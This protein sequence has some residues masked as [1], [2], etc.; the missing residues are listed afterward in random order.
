MPRVALVDATGANKGLIL[1]NTLGLTLAT[2]LDDAEALKHA[3]LLVFNTNETD[4]SAANTES[5]KE[6]KICVGV[7]VWLGDQWARAMVT[8]CN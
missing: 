4:I 2:P 6:D 5:Y 1:Q 8:P 3:G 7:Y